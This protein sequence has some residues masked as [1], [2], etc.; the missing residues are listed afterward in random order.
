MRA[1]EFITERFDYSK[2]LPVLNRII[3]NTFHSINSDEDFYDATSKVNQFFYDME[4]DI[5]ALILAPLLKENPIT[6]NDNQVN[7]LLMSFK[8]EFGSKPMTGTPD[9]DSLN[10]HV[11]SELGKMYSK[12]RFQPST[13]L[14]IRYLRSLTSFVGEAEFGYEAETHNGL[15]TM[16]VR[17]TDI[18]NLAFMSDDSKIVTASLDHLANDIIGKLMHE[19]KHYIQSTKVAKNMGYNAQVNKFY[20]GD[21]KKLASG[22]Y[23]NQYYATSDSGYW[24]NADE[25]DSWA[26]NAASEINSIFGKDLGSRNQY[27]QAVMSGKPFTYHGAPVDTTLNTYRTKIFDKRRK[28][29]VDRNQLWRKF[30][31][32]VYANVQMYQPAA[33]PTKVQQHLAKKP[34]TSQTQPSKQQ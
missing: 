3:K 13:D 11:A 33:Q 10:A 27:M 32:D 2:Y 12:Q 31:K 34:R 15:I 1:N 6:I 7:R 25:M 22:D 5:D 21:K 30:V 4:H 24:L 16:D 18:A 9:V 29:H 14:T 8:V 19:I 23:R 17:G 26:A 20:S 28:V